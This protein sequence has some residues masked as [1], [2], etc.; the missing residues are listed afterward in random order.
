MGIGR[1]TIPQGTLVEFKRLAAQAIEIARTM[2]TGTL[3]YEIFFNDEESECIVIER[4]KDSEALMDHAANVA[5]VMA[6][7]FA[8]AS[9]TSD[10]LGDP[11]A[12]LRTQVADGN[13][14]LFRSFLS[15]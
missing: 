11:S 3:Q 1:F 14:R 4:Y 10:M 9:G 13:V 6:N 5:D 7:I 2:D 12:E 15:M 8:T